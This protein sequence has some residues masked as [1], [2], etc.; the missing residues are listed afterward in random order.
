MNGFKISANTNAH[1]QDRHLFLSPANVA[2]PD[3]VGKY[4]FL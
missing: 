4:I 1:K 2:I 3:E